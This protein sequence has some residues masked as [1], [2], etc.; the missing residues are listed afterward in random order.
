MQVDGGNRLLPQAREDLAGHE[1]SHGLPGA[2]GAAENQDSLGPLERKAGPCPVEGLLVPCPRTLRGPRD[3][4]D[5][6]VPAQVAVPGRAG[7][8]ALDGRDRT[9]PFGRARCLCLPGLLRLPGLLGRLNRLAGD[10]PRIG[11]G[12]WRRIARE[13]PHQLRLGQ[14]TFDWPRLDRL[15]LDRL[16]LDRPHGR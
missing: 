1:G 5:A 8:R 16:G 7:Q 3:E 10:W 15:G 14:L 4:L 6:S 2:T 13:S 11:A 9:P 12:D